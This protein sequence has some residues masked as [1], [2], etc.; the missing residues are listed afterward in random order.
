VLGRELT[1][2]Y[3]EICRSS[4]SSLRETVADITVRGEVTLAVGGAP[5]SAQ[6]EQDHAE[7]LD[8]V[9]ETALAEAQRDGR[10]LRDVVDALAAERPG[11][12]REIYRRVLVL[13]GK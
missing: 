4:L 9:I 13:A 10:S 8:A 3:E 11:R 7:D 1:K 12:R 5:P 6:G 2:R